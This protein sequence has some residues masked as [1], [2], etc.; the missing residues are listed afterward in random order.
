MASTKVLQIRVGM[1]SSDAFKEWV[2]N[3][4]E[5]ANENAKRVLE[6]FISIYG[7]GNIN[8]KSVKIKM[9]QDFLLAE[10]ALDDRLFSRYEKTKEVASDSPKGDY[11]EKQVVV[12]ESVTEENK[13]NQENVIKETEKK[14]ESKP[15]K[16]VATN[17]NPR[18]VRQR[19]N[20]SVN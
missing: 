12:N 15:D 10:N 7:T 2:E 6:H 19:R 20:I 17:D 9:S 16:D 13:V 11:T 3:Q 8:E 14:V 4:G 1:K 18:K 5:D